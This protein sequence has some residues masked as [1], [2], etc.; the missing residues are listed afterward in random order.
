MKKKHIKKI[1]FAVFLSVLVLSSGL[2][3]YASS[4][5]VEYSNPYPFTT[6]E[7]ISYTQQYDEFTPILNQ[8]LY[9]KEVF[10]MFG[11]VLD[12]DS[13]S[14]DIT[15]S[16]LGNYITCRYS[17]DGYENTV[18][19][20]DN[21]FYCYRIRYFKS[22]SGWSF[23]NIYLYFTPEMGVTN[24]EDTYDCQIVL[25]F[26]GYLNASGSGQVSQDVKYSSRVSENK[27]AQ[28]EYFLTT[29]KEAP[30][31]VDSVTDGFPVLFNWIITPFKAIFTPEGALSSL[32]VFFGI[33]I[34]ISVILLAIKVFRSSIWGS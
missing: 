7:K 9:I 1:V 34:S 16:E 31:L 15:D 2:V 5:V 8:Y 10:Q 17:G 30:S 3:S 26:G 21:V 6:T 12:P 27:V 18:F 33:T 25:H 24:T 23:N 22:M 19:Q 28:G 4:Y 29:Y 13:D 11:G 32:A 20:N 14:S